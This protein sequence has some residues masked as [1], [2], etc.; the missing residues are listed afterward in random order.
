MILHAVA[1]HPAF[2][3]GEKTDDPLAMY[4]EDIFSVTANLAGLPA[5]SLPTPAAAPG[6]QGTAAAGD[7]LPIGVQLVAPALQEARLLAAA[8]KLE[9]L[10]QSQPA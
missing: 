8:A 5:I 4:L 3:L 10:L 9:T 2:K 7:A 1:P 6:S